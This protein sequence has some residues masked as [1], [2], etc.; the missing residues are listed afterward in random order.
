[1]ARSPRNPETLFSELTEDC[2]RTFG[3]DLESVILYGSAAGQD[4]TPERSD[5]N[6]MIVLSEEGIDHLERALPLV[7]K[8]RRK[9]AAVPLVVTRGYVQTSVDVFP[10]EYL[11]FQRQH[12]VL[13]GPNV[14]QSLEFDPEHLR[15]QCEREI[16]GKLLLLREGFLEAR[17]TSKALM[18]LIRRS[19]PAFIAIFQAL[20]H[21][22][23]Q[24]IPETREDV[25]VRACETFELDADTFR[26]LLAVRAGR[27]KL[28]EAGMRMLFEAYLREV[29]QLAMKV[30]RMG[31]E[32]A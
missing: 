19:L 22:Q 10:I 14:L 7:R 26:E 11:S 3:K 24:D 13:H 30:D 15:L 28:K 6:I 5:I 32:N 25:A 4:Y 16:K 9:G 23:G 18:E 8:W 17:G 29:R 1:M 31:G 21:L 12:R 2:R 27:V 20:L